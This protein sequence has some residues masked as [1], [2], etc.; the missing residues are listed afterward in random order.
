[1]Y[2]QGAVRESGA[3]GMFRI[4]PLIEG[5]ALVTL[6]IDPWP[7]A[8]HSFA[9]SRHYGAVNARSPHVRA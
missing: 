5:A 4:R 9:I 3:F 6:K 7:I 1:M 2:K 8:F